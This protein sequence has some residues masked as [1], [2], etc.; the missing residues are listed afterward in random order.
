MRNSTSAPET[1][2]PGA[3]LLLVDDEPAQ[4]RTLGDFLEGVGYD[5]TRAPSGV[6][7][8]EYLTEDRFDVVILDLKM[9][10][11]Q[12]TQV[13]RLMKSLAP[14]TITV[15]LTAYGTLESA[16]AGIR[17]GAFDFLHKPSSVQKIVETIEAGLLKRRHDHVVDSD[18][19]SS[20][21][22]ALR[23]LKGRDG[24]EVSPSAQD[25]FFQIGGLV[26]DRRRH[27]VLVDDRPVELTPTEYEI[28]IYMMQHPD[29]IVSGRE[30]VYHLRGY[31][32]KEQEARDF[33][34]SHLYRL[35]RK[36]EAD[37]AN[38]RYVVSIRGRGYCLPT[39]SD[40]L[41]TAYGSSRE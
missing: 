12:G 10:D 11:I 25:R 18:P 21:E 6:K 38:P 29:R 20:I 27:R 32:I 17:Y 30:I 31:E 13:L 28:L 8:L 7:A 16:I 26:V 41:P 5:V 36:I 19:I 4:L 37:P 35:R 40:V 15:I 23:N 39:E 3:R 14:G 1:A 22:Q 34:S 9:P 24:P 2:F 33:L